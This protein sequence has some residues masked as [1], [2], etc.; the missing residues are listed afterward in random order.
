M[1]RLLV[2]IVV[3]VAALFASVTTARA[4]DARRAGTVR[5]E[6]S[7]GGRGPLVLLATNDGFAGELGIV[8]EGKEPLVVS[9][10][11]VRGDSDSP[12]VPPKLVA[13][14][15]EGTLPVTIPPGAWKKAIVQWVPERNV[16]QRQLFAH[17]VVTTSDEQSGEVA[18]GVRAQRPGALAWLEG[19]LLTLV[20]AMPLL[21]AIAAFI[22]RAAGRRDGRAEHAAAVIALAVQVAVAIYVYRGFAPDVS[23]LDGNDGLQ[24]IEHAVWIRSLA[25]ELFLGVD[26]IG[27]ACLVLACVVS[28]LAI[29]REGSRA[30]PGFYP[31]FLVLQ[32][33]LAGALVAMDGLL[34]VMFT[35]LAVIASA[36]LVAGA[37]GMERQRAATRL[38][39]VGGVA[40]I[41]LLLATVAVA[42]N[43]DATFLVDGTRTTTTFNLAELSRVALG[44]KGATVLGG[45]LVKVAFGF[46]VVASMVL[47]GVFP[48]HGAL[49]G[50]IAAADTSA[51]VIVSTALP[52][53]GACALLR[54]GCAVLPEGMRWGSGVVVALGA[55]SAAYGAL[56]SFAEGD[57]RRMAAFA[58]TSQAGFVLLGAGSLTAQGIAGAIVVVAMR[59]L[60]CGSFLMLAGA[61]D[62]RARTRDTNRLTG[63]GSEM[64]G[65][66][67][68]LA[69]AA[70]GQAGVLGLGTAWGPL[71]GL[72]GAM[73]NYAPLA[74][75]AAFALVVGSAAHLRAVGR[76]AFGVL[77]A[78]WRRDPVL[79]PHGGRFVD[80]SSREWIGIAPL[81]T[82]VVVLGLWPAPI[83]GVTSGTVRDLTYAVSPPGP[84]RIAER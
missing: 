26:G 60:A 48:F 15:V 22:L 6:A 8:N 81:A 52:T 78:A 32:A 56:A 63:I 59:S 70:L 37:G 49:G 4:E 68:V 28:L 58:T 17:V 39:A 57:L 35:S 50:A 12:R 80:L 20:L 45:S 76:V 14:L 71:L 79:A 74:L 40:V 46:V 55:V 1:G 27:A 66:A 16:R 73:P 2:W 13:R 83:V 5:L 42:R 24:Y 3:V 31:A 7:P 75:V 29:M 53:I 23:R 41:L 72:F 36:F 10:I 21:G 30:V 9:R 61:V 82:L 65:F 51:G 33:S 44:A 25:A 11:A 67:V 69:I 84:E 62:D 64:P 43:A 19:S 34:F 47:L 18:M 38:A 54:I 77:D